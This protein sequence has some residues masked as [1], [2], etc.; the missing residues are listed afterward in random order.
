[1]PRAERARPWRA[2]YNLKAWKERRNVQLTAE[3][4]CCMCEAEGQTT[5]ATIADHVVPHRGDWSLFI[6]GKLQSLCKFHHDAAKQREERF[7]ERDAR[8]GSAESSRP[9]P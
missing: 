2:F 7:A 8:L 4:F 9:L 3:P 5:E 1:M 6:T